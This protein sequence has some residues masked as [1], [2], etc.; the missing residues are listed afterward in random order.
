M[1]DEYDFS[2]GERGKFYRPN[3]TFHLPVHLDETVYN[4]FPEIAQAKGIDV[5][6]LV[7]YLRKNDIGL[8]EGG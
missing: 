2:K 1:R 8:I 3:A 4:Y 7:N 6:K 5:S